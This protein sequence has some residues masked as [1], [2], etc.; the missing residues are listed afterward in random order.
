LTPPIQ[1]LPLWQESLKE[2]MINIRTQDSYRIEAA[3]HQ[4]KTLQ[5]ELKA[6]ETSIFDDEKKDQQMASSLS[7]S[8]S[9][10]R[11]CAYSRDFGEILL[12]MKLA[13]LMIE[14]REN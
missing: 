9:V 7:I 4:L 2:L 11:L 12:N 1:K 10:R 13:S 8:E 3:R 6:Y 5:I 14:V